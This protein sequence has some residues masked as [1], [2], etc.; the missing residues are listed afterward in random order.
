MFLVIKSYESYWEVGKIKLFEV[1]KIL[2]NLCKV[3]RFETKRAK[4]QLTQYV[5]KITA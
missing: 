5:L 2:K 4:V 3:K 1:C